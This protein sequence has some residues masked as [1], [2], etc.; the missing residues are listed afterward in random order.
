MD[1]KI[2]K[3]QVALFLLIEQKQSESLS[4]FLN[5]NPFTIDDV[6]SL[7]MSAKEIDESVKALTNKGILSFKII[8]GKKCFTQISRYELNGKLNIGLSSALAA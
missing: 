4:G 6:L 2:M 3:N 8:E 7:G 5:P 1:H